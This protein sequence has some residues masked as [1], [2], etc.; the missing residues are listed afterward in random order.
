MPIPD[1]TVDGLLPPF[2]GEN[3]ALQSSLMS[4]YEVTVEEF[5][6]RF[7]TNPERIKILVDWMQH[8]KALRELGVVEGFQWLDGSFV[9]NKE[10]LRGCPPNDLD[11]IMFIR[12]PMEAIDDESWHS[13][14][15]KHLHLFIRD[16]I[17][18]KF[19][20]DAFVFE[21]DASNIEVLLDRT[22]YFLQLFTHQRDTGIWKGMLRIGHQNTEQETRLLAELISRMEGAAS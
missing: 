13:L 5:V 16:H 18:Q 15:R 21:L 20:L 3:P 6:E 12:R 10:D 14:V 9:E 4:P 2:V 1:F 7:S 19:K 8:R 17:K 11:L 22:R